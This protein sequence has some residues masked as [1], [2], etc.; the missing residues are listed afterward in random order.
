MDLLGGVEG[1]VVGVEG[2]VEGGVS[3]VNGQ[4]TMSVLTVLMLRATDRLAHKMVL[5]FGQGK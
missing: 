5:Q 4:A 2:G 1:G 3:E